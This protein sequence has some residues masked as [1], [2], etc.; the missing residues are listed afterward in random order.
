MSNKLPFSYDGPPTVAVIGMAVR[1]PGA[2]TPEAFW[3]NLR[4]GVESVS[5]FSDADLLTAGAPLD[6]PGL[7]RTRPVLEDPELF[8]AAFFGYSPG[9][10][11]TID[12]QHRVFLECAW[13]AL[14]T[15]GHDP[16]ADADLA[17]SVYAGVGPDTYFLHHLH[18]RGGGALQNL[19][20][21]SGDFLAA[22]VSYQLDLTGPSV[23]VQAGCSTSLVAVHL[24]VQS[25]LGG[26]SDV[27]LAG[28]AT[29]YFPQRG[30][31]VYR[32]GGVNSPD[33]HCRAFDARAGGTT[34]GDGVV[35]LALRRLSD[36]VEAGDPIL[37]LIRGTAINNDGGR[38]AGFTA[39]AVEPQVDAVTEALAVARVAP[40][41]VDYVEAHGTG[42]RMGDA[43]EITALAEGYAGAPAGECRIGTAKPNVGDTWAAA[44]AVGLAKVLL[45]FEH[46]E[47]PPTINCTEPNPAIDFAATPFRLNTE[48]SEWKRGDRPRRA[49][50]HTF[51]MGGTNAHV[52]LEEPPVLA[53][54]TGGER[55]EWDVLPLSA[56]SAA[57]LSASAGRLADH[58]EARPG[59]PLADVAHTLRAGRTPFAHRA[60]V[61]ARDIPAAVRA[62]RSVAGSAPGT[63]GE[64]WR[65]VTAA[66][67]E[68]PLPARRWLDGDDAPWPAPRED[69]RRVPLPAYPFE[70][71]RHWVEPPSAAT[72]PASPQSGA[73]AHPRPEL[74]VPY[75]PP[76]DGLEVLTA[77]IWGEV[78]GIEGIGL[79][80]GFFD[81][82]GNSLLA[83]RVIAHLRAT[84]PIALDLTDLLG[85]PPT[86]AG[87]A[88]RVAR[89]L[90]DKL[91]ALSDEEAAALAAE[92][93]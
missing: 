89:R 26:E 20:G 59:L 47:L 75:E 16:R 43:L 1:L 36:A 72:L 61:L 93:G 18:P 46:E 29:I 34:P 84:L 54:R 82:G 41:D 10:A 24:A 90:Y 6:D 32:E 49:T 35:V 33:G 71:R 7:V 50:V 48:P 39:P 9:E 42:T 74:D 86:V 40:E 85:D 91:G 38:K 79:H 12:P 63:E 19:L 15:A 51:G 87:Q 5:T 52:V 8:D 3:N 76:A 80:D 77:R 58:L 31:Y 27:A 83:A 53:R 62:L 45:A 60:A 57:A 37:G 69:V 30:G 17:V 56:R 44:G 78:L 81:L 28:G 67:A 73:A 66:S 88:D 2:A 22:R 4:A 14:E 21:N 70:R 65:V 92:L 11:A 55:G 25:L 23:N 68:G 64:G 13:E